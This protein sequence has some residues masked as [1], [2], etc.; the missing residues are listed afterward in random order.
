MLQTLFDI[1]SAPYGVALFGPTGVITIL[2]AVWCVVYAILFSRK[3][4]WNAELL[5]SLGVMALIEVIL[6]VVVPRIMVP[7]DKGELGIA[8]RGYGV[9][10]LLG[11]VSGV[12]LSVLRGKKVGMP[13]DL[14][15]SLALWIF[16]AGMIGA[17]GF[18]VIEYWKNFQRENFAD[19]IAAVLNITEGGL[20]VFGGLIGALGAILFFARKHKLPL[21]P[22][23]D[24]AT[25]GMM[26][27]LAFGRIGCFFNGCCFG[28]VCDAPWAVPFPANT[29]PHIRQVEQGRAFGFLISGRPVGTPEHAATKE[30]TADAKIVPTITLVESDSPAARAGLVVGDVV[31]NINDHPINNVEQARAALHEG[32]AERHAV[33][34]TTTRG[35][36]SVLP[37]DYMW[38]HSR[39]VHP[40]QLYSSFDAFLAT[41]LLLAFTPLSRRDGET[42][43]LFLTVHA[44]SRFLLEEIRIDEPGMFGTQLSISQHISIGL[45]ALG[46]GLWL[47]IERKP[48]GFAWPRQQAKPAT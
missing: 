28:D 18:Y 20:V 21:L 6:I 10:F 41:L 9:M 7:N 26:L 47:Y 3:S 46:V 33:A 17:R 43:A 37:Y 16:A 12:G 34:I 44:V 29:P 23:A 1:P 35:A 39:P 5:S 4:G 8:I 38:D 14:I 13:A 48:P 45:L 25:P 42:F 19:T 30:S 32:F 15:L 31:T 40:A 24:M 2:W 36:Y 27:G 22:L 11:I